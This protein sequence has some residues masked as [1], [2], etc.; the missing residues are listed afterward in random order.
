MICAQSDAIYQN[1][2][3]NCVSFI[4]SAVDLVGKMTQIDLLVASCTGTLR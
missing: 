1:I 2:R 3:V 4:G